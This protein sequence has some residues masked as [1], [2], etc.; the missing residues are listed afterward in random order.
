MTE[1]KAPFKMIKLTVNKQNLKV[2]I[3]FERMF[4]EGTM[5]KLGTT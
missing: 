1:K 4:L 5:D 3:F 2:D